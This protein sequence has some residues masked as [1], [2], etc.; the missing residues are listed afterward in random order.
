MRHQ[1][2]LL[3]WIAGIS[4]PLGSLLGAIKTGRRPTAPRG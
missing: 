2:P 3:V 1:H 4:L